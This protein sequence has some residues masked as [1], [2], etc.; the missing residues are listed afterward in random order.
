MLSLGN[1]RVHV[2]RLIVTESV[3]LGLI[4]SV[5]GLAAGVLLAIIISAAGIPM[6]PPPNANVGYTAQIM[7]VPLTLALAFAVGVVAT[8]LAALWPARRVSRTPVIEA[9]R[10]NI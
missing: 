6:P 9:L 3:L 2:F 1:R 10:A 8:V 7:I 5:V 4:G